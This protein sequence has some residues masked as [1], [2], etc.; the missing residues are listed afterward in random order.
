MLAL[1]IIIW[2]VLI[3]ML[4]GGIVVAGYGFCEESVAAVILGI[5]LVVVAIGGMIP[6]GILMK[7]DPESGQNSGYISAVDKD[8]WGNYKVYFRDTEQGGGSTYTYYI[9]G[10]NEE[11]LKQ[12]REAMTNSDRVVV[13]YEALKEFTTLGG[14]PI[15]EITIPDPK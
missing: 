11:L 10:H 3:I 2:V 5:L 7:W 9:R 1:Y 15:V 12:A 6:S 4:I 13:K 8:Y 14:S